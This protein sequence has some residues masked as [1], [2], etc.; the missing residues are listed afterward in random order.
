MINLEHGTFR[1]DWPFPDEQ[2][3]GLPI[4]VEDLP[5]F[6]AAIVFALGGLDEGRREAESA[7]GTSRAQARRPAPFS[8]KEARGS[9]GPGPQCPGLSGSSLSA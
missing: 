2:S 6:A 5:T 1:P 7:T 8:E 9:K 4:G 3:P